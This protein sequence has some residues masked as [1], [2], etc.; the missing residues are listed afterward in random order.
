MK[1]HQGSKLAKIHSN[2][3]A[4]SRIHHNVYCG[5]TDAFLGRLG[6]F[7]AFYPRVCDRET[8]RELCINLSVKV[9]IFKQN[10]QILSKSIKTTMENTKV[11]IEPIRSTMQLR[12]SDIEAAVILERSFM[13]P[14]QRNDHIAIPFRKSR[15]MLNLDKTLSISLAKK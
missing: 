12:M 1:G 7:A 9:P 6:L 3:I 15:K 4:K 13:M 2:Q 14:S 11:D 5:L 8:L 10:W